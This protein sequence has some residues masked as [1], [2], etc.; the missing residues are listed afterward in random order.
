MCAVDI[1]MILITVFPMFV[2]LFFQNSAFPWKAKTLENW[3]NSPH[4]ALSRYAAF[5]RYFCGIYSV[6]LLMPRATF[7]KDCDL[8]VF[9]RYQ[10]AGEV[11]THVK[12]YALPLRQECR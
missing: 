11:S 4:F 5:L 7:I 6:M 3:V 2:D 1:T 8:F 10:N 9:E 12:F